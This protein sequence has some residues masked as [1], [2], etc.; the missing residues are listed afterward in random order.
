MMKYIRV[1]QQREAH[2]SNLRRCPALPSI[3][4]DALDEG[5]NVDACPSAPC[6][7][8]HCVEDAAV[9]C[10]AA[11]TGKDAPD[12]VG[13]IQDRALDLGLALSCDREQDQE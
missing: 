9:V 3:T 5:I 2:H 8:H 13:Q 10:W 11:E 4:W 7:K 6:I 1:K 12:A